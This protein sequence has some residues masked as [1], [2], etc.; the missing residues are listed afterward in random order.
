MADAAPV[1]TA[2]LE[3][4]LDFYGFLVQANGLV[5]RADDIGKLYEDICRLGILLD[6]RLVL[7]WIG[8]IDAPDAEVR[9]VA[10]AGPASAY[11]ENIHI[12]GISSDERGRGPTGRALREGCCVI[13]NRFLQDPS[14]APWHERARQFGIAASVEIGRAHV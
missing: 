5:A 6:R 9:V 8:M 13:V 2:S 7:A 3:Q 12:L 14:T 1:E 11:L 10:A 4:L